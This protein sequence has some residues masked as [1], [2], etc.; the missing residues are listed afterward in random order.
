MKKSVLF[1]IILIV[2]IL[3]VSFCFLFHEKN[4]VNVIRLKGAKLYS[5][6]SKSDLTWMT[7][8]NYDSI[9]MIPVCDNDI[10]YIQFDKDKDEFLYQYNKSDG[11]LLEFRK[12]DFRL[13]VNNKL[14]SLRIEKNDSAD[15]WFDSLNINL[16]ENLRCIYLSDDITENNMKI[17]KKLAGLKPNPGI[18]IDND[19]AYAGEV[20]DMF[21]PLWIVDFNYKFTPADFQKL[22]QLRHLELL[23]INASLNNLEDISDFPGLKTL[24]IRNYNPQGPDNALKLTPKLKALSI[25][26][27]EIVNM[28][29]LDNNRKLKELSMVNCESLTD[30][31][32]VKNL[33]KLTTLN[34]ISCDELKNIEVLTN[35]RKLKWFSLP[36][37]IDQQN[38]KIF[39]TRD[40]SI[41]IFDLIGCDSINDISPLRNLK[42][43]SCLDIYDT[44]VDID[45][46]VTLNR[47]KYL[48]L[49]REITEDSVKVSLIKD[50]LPET[51]IVPSLGLCLGTG[52]ILLVVPFIY[53]FGFFLLKT[54]KILNERNNA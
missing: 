18:Y 42:R 9:S 25:F 52:W 44:E 48:S 16:I 38:F 27:S 29:F 15:E 53:L 49:P 46:L 40:K 2:V 3:I 36:N 43:L 28:E 10:I 22:R 5:N 20:L 13:F 23:G 24:I 37:N 33:S 50:R 1:A 12:D 35:L 45:T 17:L 41:E 21:N 8:N 32:S 30:I 19:T 7:G 31:G 51:I 6:L 11:D 47:L 26:E 4:N 34:L 14:V 39:L 54:R